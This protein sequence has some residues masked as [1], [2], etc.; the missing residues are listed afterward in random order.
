MAFV[1]R[2]LWCVL[3][4]FGITRHL[5]YLYA[6]INMKFVIGT[7][8]HNSDIFC[9]PLV[10][11]YRV[12]GGG[13]SFNEIT[14]FF[15]VTTCIFDVEVWECKILIGRIRLLNLFSYNYVVSKNFM[16]LKFKILTLWSV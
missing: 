5:Y 15:E 7:L 10:A 4:R 16:V 2:H 13:D 3:H 14:A 8:G 6:H 1:L 11:G 12:V 9:W